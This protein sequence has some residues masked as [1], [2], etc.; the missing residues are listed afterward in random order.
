MCGFINM[1]SIKS[2]KNSSSPTFVDAEGV[3]Q[4]EFMAKVET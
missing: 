3:F 1:P 2:F 4:V